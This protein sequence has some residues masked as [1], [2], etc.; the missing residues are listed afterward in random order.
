MEI[1]K[2]SGYLIPTKIEG[3]KSFDVQAKKTFL[4]VFEKEADVAETCKLL[5]IS[6]RTFY[7]HLNLD[8]R[9]RADYSL[10]LRN[11]E[12]HMSSTFYKKGLTQNNGFMFGMAWL[13]RH[14][15]NDWN[16]KSSV[17][18]TSNDAS[19]EDLFS[20]LRAEGKLID[21]TDTTSIST[22]VDTNTTTPL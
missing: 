4:E 6:T 12:S 17:S 2:D 3:K 21:V 1:D 11:M 9:F 15:P 20:S 16:P 10:T 22:S 7:D 14:F 13:R 18:V 8:S 5:G 19:V